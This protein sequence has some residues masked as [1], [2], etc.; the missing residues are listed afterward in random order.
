LAR[1]LLA[2]LL[3]FALVLVDDDMFMTCFLLSDISRC[4]TCLSHS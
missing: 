4:G 3:R 2:K 1:P